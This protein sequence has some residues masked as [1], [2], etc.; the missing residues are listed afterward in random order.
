MKPNICSICCGPIEIR[1]TEDGTVYWSEGN[2]AEPVNNGR[3]CDACD[4]K[5]VIPMRLVRMM[6][7]R[8]YREWNE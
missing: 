4:A 7:A 6:T 2:N 3:C 1:R 5:I 8:N